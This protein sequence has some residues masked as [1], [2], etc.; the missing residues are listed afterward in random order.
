[1]LTRN[2]LGFDTRHTFIG[3]EWAPGETRDVLPVEDPST[4][5]TFGEIARGSPAD[6]DRAVLAARAALAGEWGRLPAVERGRVL[7]RI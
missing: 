4:G 3:G 5:E 2:D 7:T 6:I 1:M